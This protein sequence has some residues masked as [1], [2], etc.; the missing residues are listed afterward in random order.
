MWQDCLGTC[1]VKI[2]TYLNMQLQMDFLSHLCDCMM[3]KMRKG[4]VI[5]VI[6]FTDSNIVVR[7]Y[8]GK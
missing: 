3:F 2:V 1:G 6:L 7:Y 4:N 8:S 5:I